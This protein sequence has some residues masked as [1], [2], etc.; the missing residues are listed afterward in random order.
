VSQP[1]DSTWGAVILYEGGAEFSVNEGG[2]YALIGASAACAT[3]EQEQA[4]C[5]AASCDGS[6]LSAT[7]S[8]EFD[9]CISS[10][11]TGVCQ[12]YVSAA[13]AGCPTSITG[14]AS[15]GGTATTFKALY[16][17]VAKVFCE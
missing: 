7:S 2:C 10:A 3:A 6:C 4:Q 1:S 5:E 17:A 16:Q 13:T 9:N 15:C 8:T 12:T 11:D 14:A